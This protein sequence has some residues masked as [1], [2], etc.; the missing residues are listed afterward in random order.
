V[1]WRPEM[2]VEA[3]KQTVTVYLRRTRNI[4]MWSSGEITSKESGNGEAETTEGKN[5]KVTK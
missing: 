5:L 4:D 2:N 3:W 1:T